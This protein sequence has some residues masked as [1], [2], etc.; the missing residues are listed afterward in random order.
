MEKARALYDL[1]RPRYS[2]NLDAGIISAFLFAKNFDIVKII[3]A[4]ISGVFLIG[5]V[6]SVNHL[7]DIQTDT[8]NPVMRHANPLVYKGF[9]TREVQI[10]SSVL[11]FLIILL[12]I[13]VGMYF[14]MADL[15]GFFL[16][17]IYSVKPFRVKD[18]PWGIFVSNP[19]TGP[20]LFI[21]AYAAAT[22]RFYFPPYIILAFIFFYTT[23]TITLMKDVPDM[24]S[25]AQTGSRNFALT[26]GANAAR[27]V[28]V[29]SCL[30]SLAIF[31]VLMIFGTISVLGLPL[32][33]LSII[34]QMR[35]LM[36][37]IEVLIKERNQVYMRV[38]PGMLLNNI[39]FTI[40]VAGSMIPKLMLS[41]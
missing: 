7:S 36:K 19:L 26:F 24:D 25:D 41:V 12:S 11:P 3:L 5:F 21:F 15:I 38:L 8:L 10:I 33:V 4:C 6:C 23:E 37:P 20:V 22:S 17:I 32:I 27:K 39:F 40:S 2:I 29:F 9:S 28:G 31:L 16:T 30:A 14:I 18:R 35:I 13:P 34:I 1:F